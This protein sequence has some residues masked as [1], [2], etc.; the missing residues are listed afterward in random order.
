MIS[1]IGIDLVEKQR[2]RTVMQRWGDRFLSRM[3][4]DAEIKLCRTKGD[5][6]DAF[7]VRF[8]AKEAVLKAVGTGWT[9]G[10]SWQDIEILNGEKG[11]PVVRLHGAVLRIAGECRVHLS[12]THEKGNAAA[13]A[14]IEK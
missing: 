14:I 9:N 12:L 10:S 5:S 8:A 7:A 3:F 6:F 11:R 1:G 13:V 4:T 2:F